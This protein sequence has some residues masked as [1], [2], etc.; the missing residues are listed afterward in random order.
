MLFQ[1]MMGTTVTILETHTSTITFSEL[2]L[3]VLTL[4]YFLTL[5]LTGVEPES[6][7]T[8]LKVKA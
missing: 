4:S 8:K 3:T 5:V 2:F 1:Y 6:L 7:D